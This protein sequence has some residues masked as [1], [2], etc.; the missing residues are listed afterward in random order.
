MILVFCAGAFRVRDGLPPEHVAD[1]ARFIV[2]V[3]VVAFRAIGGII[4][5]VANSM[6]ESQI[7]DPAPVF[8]DAVPGRRDVPDR[9]DA[10]LAA[11]GFAIHSRRRI[12]TKGLQ[13]ILPANETFANMRRRRRSRWR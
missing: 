13:A 6:Q 3:G 5:A 4:G 10:Q 1:R 7:I 9:D 12:F 11:N 2:L 8:P